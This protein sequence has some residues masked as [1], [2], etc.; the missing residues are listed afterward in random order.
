MA[1][2]GVARETAAQLIVEAA[3]G[4]ACQ[5]Q[6]GHVQRPEVRTRLGGR[7]VPMPQ[8]AL[9]AAG[10][11][12]LRGSAEPAEISVER[13]LESRARLLQRGRVQGDVAG[14]RLRF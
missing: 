14:R 4:H 5:R 9:D 12:E 8:A 2:D 13:P 1:V 10:M 6:A 3:F 7:A 11:R